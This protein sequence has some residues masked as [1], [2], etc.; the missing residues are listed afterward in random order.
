MKAF[1]IG[2][3]ET[4]GPKPKGLV[5]LRNRDETTVLREKDKILERF[6]DH[7]S[8]LLNVLG[9]LYE[10]AKDKIK[11]RLLV[12][13]L[14]DPPDMNELMSTICSVQDGKAPGRDGIP[15]EIWKH[16]GPNLTDCLYK[17]MQK[18]W[19]TQKVPQD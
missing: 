18:V 17:L 13:L 14:D 4:Y 15:S 16:S 2:L 1:Y 5:Q 11:Q 10:P 8:Q 3:R 7:F 12:P 19:D 9:D 6:S